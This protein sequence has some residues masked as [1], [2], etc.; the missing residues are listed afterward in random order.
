MTRLLSRLLVL[1]VLVGTVA[2]EEEMIALNEGTDSSLTVQVYIDQNGTGTFDDGTDIALA[3]ATVTASGPTEASA[4]VGSGGEASFSGLRPGSYELELSGAET[5]GAILV[6]ARNPVVVAPFRG[7]ALTSEFRFSFFPG[8]IEGRVYRDDDDD[9]S[10]SGDADLPAAGITMELFTNETAGGDPV[11]TT[12]TAADGTYSFET[13]RPGSYFVRVVPLETMEIDG[14]TLRNVVVEPEGTSTLDYT[15]TGTLLIDIEAARNAPDGQT[16]TVRGTVTWAPDYDDRVIFFQD[17]TGGLSVFD[18]DLPE[19]SIGDRIEMTGTRGEFRGELQISP[20]LSIEILG[21]GVPPAPIPVSG[22]TLNGGEVDGQL[23]SVDGVVQSVEVLSFGNQL[24]TLEDGEGTVFTVFA[25]SRTGVEAD[26][27]SEGETFGVTGVVGTDS[28]NDPASRVEVRSP[29]D[30]QRGGS[31][32]DIA[33][34]R[35]NVGA[36]VVVEGIVTWAPGYDD[37]VIFFQ[38]ETGGISVFDFD[39]PE[40]SEGD[41]IRMRGTVGAFRGEVQIGDVESVEVLRQVPVPSPRGLTAAQLNAGVGQGE[42]VTITGTVTQVDVLS[43]DNQSVTLTDGAGTAFTVFGD[44]RTGVEPGDWTVGS[45]VRVTGVVGN[46]DRNDPAARIEVRGDGDL[47]AATAGQ[48]SVAE[49]RSMDGMTVTVEATVTRQTPWDERVY[50]L[51]DESGGISTF[52]SGAPTLN[53]GDRIRL[54]GEIGAFRGEVQFGSVDELTNIGTVTVP[55]PRLVTGAQINAGLFQGQFVQVS[56]TVASVAVVNDFGT[57]VL[58]VVDAAG[59][60]FEVFVDNRSGFDGDD[61]DGVDWEPGDEVTFNGVL[62]TDDR[63]DRPHRFE[64]LDSGDVVGS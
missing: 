33:T 62:G 51:Q 54:T 1:A 26:S 9:G 6:T 57:Q 39:L 52:H 16:V 17:E 13:L 48:V 60:A 63:N 46:D 11:A 4:E 3:G 22:A 28:R 47:E 42:L 21:S 41:L 29:E 44:S 36:T 35:E 23:V 56:G 15:F 50:F 19:L 18:F 20:V 59:T 8:Q 53:P 14:A 49:A 31:S 64:L 34:A 55:A 25:D 37:R 5:Q 30:V 10:F 45:T 40:L 2:C 32:V 24:V 43:F 12:T 27:W 61:E 7:E 58:V 38:D